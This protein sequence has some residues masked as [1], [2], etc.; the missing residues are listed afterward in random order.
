VQRRAHHLF[1]VA[2]AEIPT[3]AQ[4]GDDAPQKRP[5]RFNW[6]QVGGHRDDAKLTVRYRDHAA[7]LTQNTSANLRGEINT[8]VTVEP[9]EAVAA[10]RAAALQAD[11]IALDP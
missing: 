6:Q 4:L 10:G 2:V 11:G 5:A 3:P 1:D 9:S 7:L 8:A